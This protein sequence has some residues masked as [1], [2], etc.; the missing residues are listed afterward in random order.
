VRIDTNGDSLWARTYD[1][2]HDFDSCKSAVP[3][4]D[5]GYVLG[6]YTWPPASQWPH[7]W[8]IHVD[9]DGDQLWERAF[10]A[11]GSG[12]EW[13]QSVYLTSDG[14]YVVGGFAKTYDPDN[15]D[16]LLLRTGRDPVRT[17]T[18]VDAS[19]LDLTHFENRPN[20]F[21]AATRIAYE[22]IRSSDVRIDLYDAFGRKVRTLVDAR[23]PAGAYSAV[24]DGRNEVGDRVVGGVYFYRL[25]INGEK[26]TGRTILVR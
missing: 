16:F 10:D 11:G 26:L 7:V 5:G 20:P 3:T 17:R 13:C 14:G 1:R 12:Q 19:S 6:G 22:L 4:A 2:D 8:L 15:M 25:C 18:P 9:S 24:W 21:R 23:Q